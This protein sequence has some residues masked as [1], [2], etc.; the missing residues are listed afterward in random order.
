MRV[1]D[2]LLGVVSE[3][4]RLPRSLLKGALL[5]P[6]KDETSEQSAGLL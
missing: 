1:C 2:A 5:K 3:T 6:E 4:S